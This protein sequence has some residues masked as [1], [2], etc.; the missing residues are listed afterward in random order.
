LA[1]IENIEA[2]LKTLLGQ[3][4]TIVSVPTD[5]ARGLPLYLAKKY[6]P[7]Q[8]RLFGKQIVVLKR[9]GTGTDSPGRIAKDVI[10][11]R[12]H[13]EQDVAIV[14]DSLASWERKRLI[15]K[16]VPF[17]V[18]G[19]QL[20][21]PMLLID[22][23][24]HFPKLAASKPTHLSRAAQQTVLRQILKGDV[25]NRPMA[26]VATLLGYSAMMM[27]KIWGELSALELCAVENNG[28][29]R[30]MVFSMPS[31]Q[32]WSQA[33]PH[34]RSPVYRRHF[35]VG[36]LGGA[37]IAGTSALALYSALNP[38]KLLTNAV[39]KRRYK[40]VI[41]ENRLTEIESEEEADLVLEEWYYDPRKLSDTDVVDPL[42]LYLSLNDDPDER[43]QIA[44]EEILEKIPW[45]K[46]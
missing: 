2:Y 27:T 26:G 42:S 38:D 6:T 3:E 4:L 16:R 22:L 28:R 32:L 8:L 13:F 37:Q 9:R 45:S 20:F 18:P 23:R 36:Q 10:A 24:E 12:E 30:Q 33:A 7:Y 11:L 39:W 44:L 41:K 1:W 31:K 15:E 46:E 29:T 14:L 43:I 17:I 5:R 40:N 25:E 21:L 35:L 19:R 34:M